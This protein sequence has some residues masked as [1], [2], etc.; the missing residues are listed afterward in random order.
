MGC[1][2][3]QAFQILSLE[4]CL[5]GAGGITSKTKLRRQSIGAMEAA[6]EVL[7]AFGSLENSAV[8]SKTMLF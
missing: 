3:F 5:K 2:K 4:C 6:A 1:R 8:R 7:Q